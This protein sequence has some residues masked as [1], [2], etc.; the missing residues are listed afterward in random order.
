MLYLISGFLGRD[1]NV[2]RQ[3]I[4]IEKMRVPKKVTSK[5]HALAPELHDRTASTLGSLERL[6][7]D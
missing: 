7:P 3:Q 5:F 1:E 2:F 4:P 6:V